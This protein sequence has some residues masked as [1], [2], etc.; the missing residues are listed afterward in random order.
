MLQIAIMAVLEFGAFSVGVFL[1]VK[2]WVGKRYAVIMYVSDTEATKIKVELFIYGTNIILL[3][4]TMP[5][6]HD[7]MGYPQGPF[8]KFTHSIGYNI[9]HCW[10]KR[11]DLLPRKLMLQSLWNLRHWKQQS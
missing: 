6:S 5:H 11:W 7:D 9:Q 2:A 3:W 10:C 4:K 1:A 8:C